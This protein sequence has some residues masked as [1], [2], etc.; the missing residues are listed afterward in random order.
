MGSSNTISW[1][2]ARPLDLIT[3]LTV[4]LETS[5][6]QTLTANF[7]MRGAFCE[8]MNPPMMSLM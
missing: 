2:G 6:P 3:S 4:K 1:Q 7:G 8:F 5:I